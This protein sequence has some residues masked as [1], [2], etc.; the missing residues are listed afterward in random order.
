MQTRHIAF[1]AP[2]EVSCETVEQ[3]LVA[4]DAGALIELS[5]T[6]ISAGTELAKLSGLQPG[7]FPAGPLGNRAVGRVL[8]A[9]IKRDDL[10]PGDF[11]F[12]HGPH[13][14]HAA[15]SGLVV[16]LPDALDRPEM[17]MLG[18][19]MVA[20][21]GLRVGQPELGDAAVVIGA[22]LVG[23][24]T[25]QLLQLNG[26]KA[27][28]VDPVP[29]RLAIARQCGVEHAIEAAGA[30]EQ[31]MELTHGQ[32]AE[33]ILECTGVPAVVEGAVHFAGRS[34]QLIMIGSPRGALQ[35][36][37]TSFLNHFHLWR[38]QGDLTLKGAH[39]WKIA[40]YPELGSKHSM[41]RNAHILA[42]LVLAGK[43]KLEPL[44]TGV[45]KPEDGQGAYERLRDEQDNHLG[46][47][48]DWT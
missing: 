19:A 9:G 31:V 21:T 12:C 29:G 37:L 14:S 32:G 27:I 30:A 26:V 16:K 1:T 10:Q 46:A 6:C 17:A 42:D 36:D 39:E 34:A 4:P 22:G 23:Q 20:F 41:A 38:P 18:M 45:F 25:A 48:F 2:N 8:A 40:L 11:V 15:I 43:L 24:C 35:T 7:T 3:D 5:Y 33:Y 13:A 47:V 44:L 28:L